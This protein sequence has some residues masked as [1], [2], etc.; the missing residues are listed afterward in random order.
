MSLHKNK[1]SRPTITNNNTTS[2][3]KDIFEPKSV[4]V[5]GATE[6][7]GS[8]GKTLITNLIS[9]PFGGVIF[10]VNPKREHV[11][12]I[13]AYKSITEIGTQVDLAIISISAK[14]V[15]SVVREC[16]KV[17]VKGIIIISAGFKEMG[18]E[19]EALEQEIKDIIKGTG[20]RVIGPNCLGVMSP[21]TKLNAT[22]AP[23]MVKAGNVSIMSQSGALGT[24]I[25]DWSIKENIGF[26][27]FSSIGSMIDVDWGDLINYFGDDPNTSSI[28]IYM[29]SIGNAES[30]LSAARRVS[31][32]KPIIII[33]AGRTTAAAKAAA[34]HTGSLTGADDV[35]DAAFRRVGVIRVNDIKD[36]FAITKALATQPIPEDKNLTIV[37]NAGG[38]GVLATD[39]LYLGDGK[40]TTISKSTMNKLNSF[41]PPHWSKNNPIDI[42]G[43]ATSEVYAKTLEIAADDSNA[44]ALLVIL[45]P[46]AMS[47]PTNTAIALKPYAHSLKKP[48]YSSWMGGD[49]VKEGARLLQEAEIPCFSEPDEACKVFNALWKYKSELKSLYKESSKKENFEE[50]IEASKIAKKVLNK[51]KKEGRTLLNE[52]ESK[53]LLEAYKIPTIKTEIALTKEEAVNLAEEFGFPVVLKLHSNTITHKTDVG[54]V[55][56]NL[57]DAPSVE[58]AFLEI[59][60]KVLKIGSKNDFLG[61]TVQKMAN[62]DGYEV[63]F[64]ASTDP[65]FGPVLLFGTGGSLVE[66]YEDSSLALPPL[67]EVLAERVMKRTK[68]YKALKGVRGK[69]AVDL[70][71]MHNLFS[72]FSA[73]ISNNPLIKEL[74]INPLIASSKEIIALDA[75]VLIHKEKEQST[76][77]IKPYPLQYVSKEEVNSTSLTFRPIWEGDENKI[78]EFHKSLTKKEVLNAYNSKVSLEER[79]SRSSLIELCFS[80]YRNNLTLVSESLKDKI[81]GILKLNRDINFKDKGEISLIL[82]KE[83]TKLKGE[84]LLIKKGLQIAKKEGIKTLNLVTLDSNK[85]YLELFSSFDKTITK[86]ENKLIYINI[87]L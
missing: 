77:S 54:G 59:K 63:I 75:R 50:L 7:E 46:Q 71:K 23:G 30:F 12:G 60:E 11:L 4:A 81:I 8:V 36:L 29:E 78:I 85:K 74:D 41:L 33:K 44:N 84:E 25:L 43:D 37:T 57:K 18:P 58:K 2:P 48:V 6:R 20:I 32:I 10:P 80:D 28:V 27:S 51:A 79:I 67:N 61:V 70:D 24:A 14:Y 17:R 64:G 62:L 73:L 9:S 56:L 87:N 86:E 76:F 69:R 55:K 66:V 47:D 65:Q 35:L 83:L 40:L 15:P 3:L 49:T 82:S 68:I 39:S 31:R 19:G 53:K 13:K 16:V 1:N 5:I 45:T 21:I 22:F 26:S 72:R 38:P 52:Y 42:L 34:S